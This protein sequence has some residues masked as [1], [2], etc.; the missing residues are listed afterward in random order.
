VTTT[1]GPTGVRLADHGTSI[2]LDWR[3]PTPGSAQFAVLGG[4][5][6]TQP[7]LQQL[8]GRG[9]THLVLN[10]INPQLNYC[11]VV[12]AV[13]AEAVARSPTVCTRR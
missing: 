1:G 8:V 3:D 10:G 5:V 12:A 4:P 7:V 2:G 13:Y 6:G 11:F 9:V